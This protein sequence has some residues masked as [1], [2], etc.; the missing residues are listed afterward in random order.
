MLR[1]LTAIYVMYTSKIIYNNI[2]GSLQPIP[3]YILTL[4]K[5]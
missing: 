5:E 4:Y 2:Y 1:V 3:L